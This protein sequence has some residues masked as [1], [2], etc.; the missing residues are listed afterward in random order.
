M[1]ISWYPGHM[2]KA[3]K[4]LSATMRDTELVIEILDARAPQASSNPLLAELR[5]AL[6]CIKVLNKA[7]LANPELTRLWQRFFASQPNTRCLV[8]GLDKLLTR[9]AL[10]SVCREL[11]TRNTHPAHRHQVLITGIPNVGKS[12]FLNQILARKV[13]RTGNEPA[14]TKGQQ[15]V[16][17][18]EN[19]FLVDSPGMMWP[20]L[21][22]QQAAYRL[23][24]LGSIRNTAIDLEDIGWFAAETLL[25]GFYLQLQSR[26]R[27][28]TR[29]ADT[30]ELLTR[31]ATG[32]GCLGRGG[33]VDWH[34]VSELLLG[35]LRSGR[36]GRITLENPPSPDSTADPALETAMDSVLDSSSSSSTD[37]TN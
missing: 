7:D 20:K 4:Q 31:I 3:R 30:E 28:E 37:Q 29:P 27:L 13:A 21:E 8:N 23:A 5:G 18:E 36:L 15:K 2:H 22:D 33:H 24:V 1:P 9:S 10:M 11:V 17:L 14:V 35:D 6:P 19:W 34:K 16:K 25:A 12:T 32:H 26:Y